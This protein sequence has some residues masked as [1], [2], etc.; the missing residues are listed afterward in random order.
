MPGRSYGLD[1]FQCITGSELAKVKGSTCEKCYARKNFYR[2]WIP[3]KVAR[4]RRH[5]ALDH[6]RWVDAMVVCINHYCA[7]EPWFRWHDSGDIMSVEHLERIVE[8]CARTPLVNHWLP[9]REE[10]FVR[11]YLERR[12]WIPDNLCIRISARMVGMRPKLRGRLTNLP[13]STVHRHG[14]LP[15]MVDEHR[16]HSIACKAPERE[17]TCGKCRACWSTKVVNISYP[18]H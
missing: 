15:I 10:E 12:R 3:A 9:T 18:E 5:A 16:H 11:L 2:T 7:D 8:V 14:S 1:A 17:N 13:T 6:P 4:E